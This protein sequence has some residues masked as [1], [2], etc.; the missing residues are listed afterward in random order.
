VSEAAGKGAGIFA[1]RR[2]RAGETIVL[3][4]SA[5]YTA[6]TVTRADLEAHGHELDWYTFQV[7]PDAYLLPRGAIDDLINHSCE[8]SAGI[9]LDRG[10][11]RLLALREIR[12]GEE[13]TYDYST[14]L[15]GDHEA[16]RCSCGSRR[17][18]GLIGAF[19]DL[20]AERRRTYIEAGVVAAFVL[21]EVEPEPAWEPAPAAAE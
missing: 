17:C 7:G 3:E 13:V 14:Y 1:A 5:S 18:R 19:A 4:D 11:Y 2:F 10:G 6:R 20:P 15:A 12:P 9:R 8:P 21:D 16:M